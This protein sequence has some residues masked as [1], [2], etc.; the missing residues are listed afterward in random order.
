MNKTSI[1]LSACAFMALLVFTSCHKEYIGK[2]EPK[3]KISKIYRS[4]NNTDRFLAE[5][6]QWENGRLNKIDHYSTAS[7]IF[8]EIY[9]YDAEGFISSIED[10]SHRQQTNFIYKDKKLTHIDFLKDK[11][12]FAYMDFTYT[13]TWISSIDCIITERHRDAQLGETFQTSLKH[14][15]PTEALETLAE[16]VEASASRHH[17]EA[18]NIRM[19]WDG[20]NVFRM[21][22]TAPNYPFRI[23]K[24]EHDRK[25][26]PYRNYLEMESYEMHKNPYSGLNKN[27]ITDYMTLTMLSDST[28]TASEKKYVYTYKDNYPV[29]QTDSN[30]NVR[31]FVYEE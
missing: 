21:D 29:L 18:F 9:H 1:L 14:L 4:N 16:T 23:L 26:N 25:P 13:D 22:V 5:A 27:N 6:W 17:A 12:V 15:M 28:F 20:A 3:K 7:Y 30:G 19:A 10:T 2:F 11:D 24:F 31:E 8:S